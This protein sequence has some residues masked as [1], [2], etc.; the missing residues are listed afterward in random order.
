[1]PGNKG[2]IKNRIIQ[3]KTFEKRQISLRIFL[4]HDVKVLTLSPDIQ[5]VSD[6][7]SVEVKGSPVPFKDLFCDE[8]QTS[9]F[10][11]IE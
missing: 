5:L 11:R 4:A 6:N 10:P 8:N 3:N 1:M 7:L 9:S 2:F